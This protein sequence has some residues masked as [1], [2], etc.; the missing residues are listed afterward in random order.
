MVGINTDT[1]CLNTNVTFVI[2]AIKH[3]ASDFIVKPFVVE[4][5]TEAVSKVI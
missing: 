5:V 4:R 2:D 3:G 1:T